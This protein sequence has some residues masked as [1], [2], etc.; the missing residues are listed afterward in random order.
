MGDVINLNQVRKARAK[1][2]A[3][4][5]ADSN[6]VQHGTP[7]AMKKKSRAEKKKSDQKLE[8]KRLEDADD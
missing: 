1:A 2:E 3:E 4:K 7:K 8:G 5:A 6:R